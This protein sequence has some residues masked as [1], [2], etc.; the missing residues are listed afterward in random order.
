[1]AIDRNWKAPG[2]LDRGFSFQRLIASHKAVQ[3]AF[4]ARAPHAPWE[5]RAHQSVGG[6]AV[7]AKMPTMPLHFA[8][9]GVLR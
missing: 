7:D 6:R 1:M 9:N 3:S 8:G 4:V 2:P 5:T